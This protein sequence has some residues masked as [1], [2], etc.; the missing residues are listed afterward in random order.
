MSYAR[1]NR[2]AATYLHKSYRKFK[3]EQM[4]L[5]GRENIKTWLETPVVDENRCEFFEQ[6]DP[7]KTVSYVSPAV[8]NESNPDE[9]VTAVMDSILKTVEEKE[10]VRGGRKRCSGR[11]LP[12]TDFCSERKFIFHIFISFLSFCRFEIGV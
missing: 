9:C 3:A 12:M 6:V 2:A 4:D 7:S 8:K 5:R 11:R 10:T 1:Y